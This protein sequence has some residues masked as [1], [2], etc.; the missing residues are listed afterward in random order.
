M[1]ARKLGSWAKAN[2]MQ[3]FCGNGVGQ[4]G[5]IQSGVEERCYQTTT[6]P[7]Q[8]HMS[9]LIWSG[10]TFRASAGGAPQTSLISLKSLKRPEGEIAIGCNA[11]MKLS[12]DD[13]YRCYLY[14]KNAISSEFKNITMMRKYDMWTARRNG[15]QSG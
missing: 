8:S 12:L 3:T 11:A 7:A 1:S 9:S 13:D 4:Q 15:R 5:Q 14:T 6:P 10:Q 2:V